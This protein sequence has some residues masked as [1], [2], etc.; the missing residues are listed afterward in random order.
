MTRRRRNAIEHAQTKQQ[1]QDEET[2]EQAISETIDRCSRAL[3]PGRGE[4][5][6]YRYVATKLR[7]ELVPAI[8][9]YT[10][11]SFTEY[12]DLLGSH[13]HWHWVALTSFL[14]SPDSYVGAFTGAG[15]GASRS[16][17]LQSRGLTDENT[18]ARLTVK[19]A[20]ESL[21]SIAE[22]ESVIMDDYARRVDARGFSIK[23]GEQLQD[24]E[25]DFGDPVYLVDWQAG[26]L[27]TLFGGGTGEAKS[28][29]LETDVEDLYLYDPE[30]TDADLQFLPSRPFKIIDLVDLEKGENWFYDVPQQQEDLRE[31]RED[32][33]LP[34]DFTGREDDPRL[35][36]IRDGSKSTLEIFAPLTPKLTEIGLPFDTDREDWLVRPFVVPASDIPTDIFIN[37]IMSR[38]SNDQERTIRQAIDDVDRERDDWAL[39]HLADEIRAR[40]ELSDKHKSSAIAVLRSLQDEGF[41]R[42][43]Q[44]EHQLDWDRIFREDDVV[45]LFTQAQDLCVSE[46]GQMLLVAYLLD[47]IMRLRAGDS[48][49]LLP[50]LL[51][52]CRELWQVVPHLKR[53]VPDDRAAAIQEVTGNR[54]ARALRRNRHYGMNVT[55]DTQKPYDLLNSVREMFNRYV[56]YSGTN[57]LAEGVFD[58]TSNNKWRSFANTLTAKRGQAGV[59][60]EV[61][62]AIERRHIEFVSPVEFVPPSHHHY[63]R[64]QDLS[65]WRARAKYL[66]P[67]VQ[68]PECGAGELERADTLHEVYCDECG[69][70]TLD[71]SL[72]RNEELR[73]PE[74]DV[75]MPDFLEIEAYQT[76]DPD[77]DDDVDELE[78]TDPKTLHRAEAR[79]RKRRGESV[80]QIR[81]NIPNNPETENPYSLSTIHD[82]IE[83]VAQEGQSGAGGTAEAD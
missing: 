9:R 35:E 30:T 49:K 13:P 59:V 24:E 41:I 36:A 40:P 2:L 42:T 29:G 14:D 71:L 70:T 64:E 61:H 52:V 20:L 37:A 32:H 6:H 1:R 3:G 76:G 45:T 73:R 67:V 69:K 82:W 10:D 17:V 48:S 15:G 4:R 50:D 23:V 78:S 22:R 62:P 66:T 53:E 5:E 16:L 80:R 28:S 43:A 26:G 83:D 25:M 55:A 65:G 46:V 44:H 81:E 74:W 33:G 7:D 63:D 58:W 77:D 27:K 39:T 54:L 68:C 56:I 72:G 57:K 18:A 12:D 38:V 47:K 31:M 21:T 19:K 34:Q 60:G 51:L 8:D 11:R 79:N 75:S